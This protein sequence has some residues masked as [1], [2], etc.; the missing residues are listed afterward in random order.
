[1]LCNSVLSRALKAALY[2]S[3][4]SQCFYRSSLSQC[5]NRIIVTHASGSASAMD[6]WFRWNRPVRCSERHLASICCAVLL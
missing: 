5:F 6:S 4:L 2:R 3:S 1:M